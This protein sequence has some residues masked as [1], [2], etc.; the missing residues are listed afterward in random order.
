MDM[1]AS[2]NHEAVCFVGPARSGKTIGL[3]DAW[4]VHCIINDPGDFLVAQMTQEK[5]REYSKVRIDRAIRNSPA[6]QS[7]MSLRRNDDNTH[8]KLTRHGMWIKIGWPSATQL[9]SSDYRYTAGTDYDRW[10][11]DIDGEGSG[12][13]LLLKRTQT[14]LSRGMCVVESSPGRDYQDPFWTPGTPHE[15]P[16][17]TGILGVYNRSDRRRW[18]WRCLDCHVYFEA[19][20]GLALFATLPPESELIDIVRG[21]DLHRL[22]RE[23]ARIVCPHCGSI[24][25]QRHKPALNDPAT[26]RWVPDGQTVDSDGALHGEAIQSSIAGYWLG[27]VAAAYQKWD[28]I[29]LRYLQG[30]REYAL[31]GSDLTLKAT[32]NTDQGMPYLPR[33]LA[34]DPGARLDTRVEEL[35]RFFVPDAARFLVAAVDV[36]GGSKARFVVQVH[37]IGV[38]MEQWL[39]DRYDI[40]DSARGEARI[41]PAGYPEDWDLLTVRVVQATYKLNDG[42]ELAVRAVGIDTGG[43]DGVTDMAYGWYQRL[44]AQRLHDR[45]FLLKGA[46]GTPRWPVVASHPRNKQGKARRDIALHLLD[47]NHFKDRVDASLR[48]R[49]PGPTFM[50]L[51]SWLKSWWFDELRA[52]VRQKNGKWKKIRDRNEALDLWCYVLAVTHILG[53]GDPLK[54]FDW[55]NPPPW[56]APLERNSHV[57]TREERQLRQQSVAPGTI[58]RRAS[59]WW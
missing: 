10:P 14:F 39:I 42:R 19:A 20:P 33:H 37:A 35:P 31:S 6:L 22:A 2:R 25:E 15:A 47:T 45:V 52:E 53:P 40:T 41:D 12:Y 8:D 4:L 44:R 26:A 5:A 51:P 29:L 50:H 28:S 13:S 17:A 58:R 3:L 43:E 11:D 27:G 18:Y 16:P 54:R 57:C 32:I 9:S 48:R 49:E 38:D 55:N 34:E 23:H 7:L 46:S 36:Q 56:A 24:I 59:S 21:A 30:M 1:L